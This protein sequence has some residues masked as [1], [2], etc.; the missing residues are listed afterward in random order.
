MAN[1]LG[2]NATAKFSY[3]ILLILPVEQQQ[4]DFIWFFS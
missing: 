4:V 2:Q 1:S 3:L